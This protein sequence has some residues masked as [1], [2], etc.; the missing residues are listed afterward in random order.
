MELVSDDSEFKANVPK[1]LPNFENGNILILLFCSVILR[2]ENSMNIIRQ[3]TKQGEKLTY[4]FPVKG[5]KFLVK[6]FTDGDI[7][8]T[9]DSGDKTGILIPEN[10]AQ[11]CIIG[12]SSGWGLYVRDTLYI[13]AKVE[14]EKGVEVQC[15]RW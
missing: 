3:P 13:T 10:A 14:S 1:K 2:K 7:E 4:K 8:V 15:L 9:F 5:S 6:N 11:I 12:E